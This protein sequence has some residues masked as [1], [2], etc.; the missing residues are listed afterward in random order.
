MQVNGPWSPGADVIQ[1]LPEQSKLE[2]RAN[3]V[4]TY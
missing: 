4:I 3:R 2:R 1:G